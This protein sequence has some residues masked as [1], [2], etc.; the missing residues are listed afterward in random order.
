MRTL[1]FGAG[2]VGSYIGAILTSIGRDVTLVARGAQYEALATRGVRLDGPHSGR[3]EPVRVNVCREGEEQPPYDLVFVTLKAHHVGVCAAHLC[4]MIGPEGVLLFGQNGIPWW[5]FQGIDSPY[6][7]AR[8]PSLDP[9]GLL[10]SSFP[11]KSVV[12]AV[13]YKPMEQ[14]APGHVK[15]ADSKEDCLTVGEIDNRMTPRLERIKALIEPAGWPVRVT[16]DIRTPKWAKLLSN[17]IWNPLGAVVQGTATQ[18]AADPRIAPL[19]K[20]MIEEVIAVARSVGIKLE[21]DPVQ[22]VAEAAKRVSIA[23]STLQDVRAG[24]RIEIEVLVHAITEIGRL[25]GVPTP[26]LDVIGACAA[27]INRRIIE[28]KVAFGPRP[29]LG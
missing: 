2:A 13:M 14:I 24:R 9:D 17:A 27:F 21:A 23:S 10:A 5:Y 7:T 29:A 4:R 26:N 16:T 1:I 20:A 25:T 22:I 19:A 3:P 11:M 6:K 12:G 15:L 18:L 8:L 28:D